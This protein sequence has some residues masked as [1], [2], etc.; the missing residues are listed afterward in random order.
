LDVTAPNSD[1]ATIAA[2]ARWLAHRYDPG[3]DAFHMRHVTR[4]AHRAATFLTDEYLSPEPSPLILRRTDVMAAAPTPAPVHF[5]FH[6]AFCLSTLLARAFD[7]EGKTL[8]LKEPMILNDLAGWRQRGAEPRALSAVLDDSLTLLARPMMGEERVI[9]KPSNVVNGL[10]PAILG[11]R[12]EAT[13]VLLHAPLNTYL[14]SIAK[15]G[16]W[17]RLWVRDL[18]VK[19][20]R[21]GLIDLGFE[22]EAYLGLTDLQAAAVGWLAQQALF[23][24]LVDL[25]GKDRVKTLDSETIMAR[26][27]DTVGALAT[28]FDVSLDAPEVHA[29]VE[30]PAFKTHSK[31]GTDFGAQARQAE[32]DEAAKVHGEEIEKVSL[33]AQAVADNAGVNLGSHNPLT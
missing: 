22:D 23:V 11:L 1:L 2:D 29:V 10:A 12:P 27:L 17:G 15:K 3:H 5:I 7:I 13:A 9:V 18:L 14:R 30:G 24:R 21:E 8:G 33:W 20:L 19:L 4:A 28:H 31:S 32:Y 16:M 6:S 26:P 25:F